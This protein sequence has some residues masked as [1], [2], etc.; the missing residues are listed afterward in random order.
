VTRG[1]ADLDLGGSVRQAYFCRASEG[2]ISRVA[3]VRQR[4]GVEAEGG[5]EHLHC[6][7]DELLISYYWRSCGSNIQCGIVRWDEGAAQP[8]RFFQNAGQNTRTRVYCL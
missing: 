2:S 1:G 5:Q 4:T 3:L 7:C 8:G 6:E